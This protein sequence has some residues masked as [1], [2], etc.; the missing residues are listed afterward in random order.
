[1]NRILPILLLVIMLSCALHN[2]NDPMVL[3]DYQYTY[4]GDVDPVDFL[5]NWIC[6]KESYRYQEGYYLFLFI[7][8]EDEEIRRIEAIFITNGERMH[9]VGYKYA[10]GNIIYFFI[11]NPETNHFELIDATSSEIQSI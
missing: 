9:L 2:T 4:D 11:L 7:N 3:S 10:K 1:M 6:D 5:N 8:P